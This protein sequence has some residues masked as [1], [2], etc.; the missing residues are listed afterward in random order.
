MWRFNIHYNLTYLFEEF[1]QLFQQIA[2]HG[3][4]NIYGQKWEHI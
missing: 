1:F 4:E 2:E 3:Y